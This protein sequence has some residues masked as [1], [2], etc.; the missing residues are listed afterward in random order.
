M[1]DSSVKTSSFHSA[2]NILL[3]SHQWQDQAMDVL[4]TD[5]YAVNGG[6]WCDTDSMCWVTVR[7]VTERSITA[8][9][10]ICLSSREP[11]SLKNNTQSR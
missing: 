3:S 4:R 9:R 2:A 7:D 5:H 8:L 6:E 10:T 1:R 11:I